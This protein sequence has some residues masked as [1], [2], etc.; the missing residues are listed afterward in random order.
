MLYVENLFITSFSLP[1]SV[2]SLWGWPLIWKTIYHPS[3]LLHCWLGHL[4][5]KIIS[6]ITYNVSSGTLN[7]TVPYHKGMTCVWTNLYVEIYDMYFNGK[8]QWE[9]PLLNNSCH[10]HGKYHHGKVACCIQPWHA[11]SVFW[12]LLLQSSGALIQVANEMLPGSTERAVTISGSPD[13]ISPCIQ[14]LC[15]IAIEVCHCIVRCK[16]SWAVSD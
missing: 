6:K 14:R 8:P 10:E 16:L 4:T 9:M 12:L 1:F 2:L 15:T 3:V 13:A 5:C 11:L 7:P